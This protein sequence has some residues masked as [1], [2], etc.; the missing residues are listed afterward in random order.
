MA[1]SE[2]EECEGGGVL[3]FGQFVADLNA[4]RPAEQVICSGGS[5]GVYHF[6][7]DMHNA[8]PIGFQDGGWLQTLDEMIGLL[9]R[10][11]PPRPLSPA[12]CSC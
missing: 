1:Y 9:L 10:P 3:F 6:G 11:L 7:W 5:G 2:K 12:L 8:A 4:A